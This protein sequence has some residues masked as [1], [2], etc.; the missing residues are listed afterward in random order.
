MTSISNVDR[1]MMILRQRL[2]DKNG[3]NSGSTANAVRSQGMSGRQ[4]IASL[5]AAQGVDERQL[6]R[7]LVQSLLAE[8]LGSALLNDARFQEIVSQVC[9]ALEQDQNS[10]ALLGRVLSD[11]KKQT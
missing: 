7:T 4:T 1:I 5:A 6:R 2:S 9:E 11:L 3:V 8:Q 10:Q